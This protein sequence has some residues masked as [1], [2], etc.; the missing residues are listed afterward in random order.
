V[1]YAHPNPWLETA[2]LN[3]VA[4]KGDANVFGSDSALCA[5]G[6]LS[7]YV[8]NELAAPINTST[9]TIN[10]WVSA[11]DDFQM[12]VP[13][14]FGNMD[15]MSPFS[16][17]I[18][19][20]YTS[21]SLESVQPISG[22]EESI[23]GE[24]SEHNHNNMNP[25]ERGA[26]TGSMCIVLNGNDGLKMTPEHYNTVFIG[27]QNVS[28][29]ALI[30]RYCL[31]N[32]YNYSLTSGPDVSIGQAHAHIPQWPGNS[33]TAGSLVVNPNW[34]MGTADGSNGFAN[35]CKNTFLSYYRIGFA[36]Y[37]GNVRY[38]YILHG[39]AL[40]TGNCGAIWVSRDT[41]RITDEEHLFIHTEY[42][43]PLGAVAATDDVKNVTM[44]NDP[45]FQQQFSGA[46]LEFVALKN[47][48]EFEHPY[49]SPQRFT[50]TFQRPRP[51][52]NNS[53]SIVEYQA[54]PIVRSRHRVTF[55]LTGTTHQLPLG[56]FMSSYVAAGED[57]SLHYFG[58][59]PVMGRFAP[60]T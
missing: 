38:K 9:V 48:I 20:A 59:A 24:A 5:N 57:F 25:N 50:Y 40:S 55:M 11:G 30:K 29:R 7:I 14:G 6:I 31:Y 39:T 28:L 56:A 19:A 13:G 12:A 2:G 27:E 21:E 8:N 49:Y 54:L 26:S 60:I 23:V 42:N 1:Q 52:I 35:Y 37:R 44:Y 58:A 45:N 18:R 53:N 51:I 34:N 15:H 41:R 47:G 22:D 10:I 33:T 17:A 46:E 4:A 16:Q 3:Q 43:N 32:R 36:A